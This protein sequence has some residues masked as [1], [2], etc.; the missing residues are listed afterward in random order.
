MFPLALIISP[1]V[2]LF[3]EPL[4]AFNLS[5]LLALILTPYC[6]YLLTRSVLG[7]LI[8]TYS[9]IYFGY[10]THIQVLNFWPVILAVYF[11]TSRRYQL[12]ALTI[13]IAATTSALFLYF[14]LIV[15]II[16]SIVIKSIRP[17][18]TFIIGSILVLPFMLPYFSVSKTFNYVRPITDAIHNSVAPI[19]LVTQFFPGLAFLYLVVIWLL[20]NRFRFKPDLYIW[21][22]IVSFIL[23]LGPAL[24]LVKN[25]IHL[26][27]IP[28]IPLPY[29]IFYY[30]VP[31]FSGIRTP[32]RF[33]LLAFFAFTVYFL[34]KLKITKFSYLLIIILLV[35]GLKVPIKYYEVPKIPAVNFDLKDKYE[36]MPVAY[37]P[38]YGWFDELGVLEETTRM[39]F[40]TANWNPMFNGYSG[41]SP[42]EWEDKV[43]WL[44][45][46]YPSSE[47]KNYLKSIGIKVIIDNGT[48]YEI[49]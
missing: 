1:F 41:F 28:F 47:A 27:L 45:K 26:G 9:P 30:L 18:V 22:G 4:L 14:V 42:R 48:I 17:I 35:V 7:S 32:S 13:P 36:G 11:L 12:L 29:A 5:F 16:Q 6:F 25:T 37:F 20:K 23:S 19:D 40:S 3:N 10:L 2:K 8:F 31:G 34:T 44:Q 39:Y 46:N 49:N 38:I 43:K 21:T 15:V 24:H 33:M